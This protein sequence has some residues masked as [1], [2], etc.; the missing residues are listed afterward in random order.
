MSETHDEI[1]DGVLERFTRT[2]VAPQQEEKFPVGPDSAKALGY[3]AR[4]IDS[5]PP[6]VTESFCGVGNPI[7]LGELQ[8]GETVLDLG[9]GAGL[10]SVL[11]ARE[12]GLAG[13]VV[14]VDM[15]EAMV[16]KARRNAKSVG[17]DNVEFVHSGIDAIPM[18]DESIDVVISNGVLNL[19]PDKP[20]VLREA[21]RVLRPGGRLQLADVLLHDDVTPEEVAEKSTWSD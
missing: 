14:G 5:L 4:E 7:G 8:P 20:K 21:F 19:C 18:E 12:V 17:L 6:A 3:G 2:A 1:R 9:S 15:T 10:D 16:D 13:K 11:A